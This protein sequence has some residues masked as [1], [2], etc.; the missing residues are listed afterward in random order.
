VDRGV[1]HGR[2]RRARARVIE[3]WSDHVDRDL[4][5]GG[6]AEAGGAAAD[7][8]ADRR[9]HRPQ[10]RWAPSARTIQR[11]FARTGLNRHPDGRAPRSYGRFEAAARNDRWTGDA[12]HGP[13]VANRKTYLL[14]FI[15]DHSRVVPGHRW[16]HAEDTVRLEAALRS[17][18][19]AR[20]IPKAVHMDNGSAMVS[21]QLLRACAVLGI[22]LV[23]ST[24]RRP[25]GRGK[26]ERFFR[27]VR[28]QFL[29]EVTTTPVADIGELNR[30]FT[31]WLE[32][33]YHR[34]VH[35]ETAEAPIDRFDA[36]CVKLPTTEQ[37]H[38]A[39]L[40][41]ETR[42][43]TKVATVSLHGN[44]YQV[45]ANLAGRKVELVF[46]PFDLTD[47]EVRLDGRPMGAAVPHRIGRH[48]HPAARP[49]PT[50]QPPAPVVCLRKCRGFG[51]EYPKS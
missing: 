37:L 28:D 48:S 8:R 34:S 46:D 40:W 9:G 26:I 13:I 18:L 27:T 50:Q 21:K 4:G 45:D 7:R 35:S 3:P 25:E 20:G 15:D 32:T 39:F 30:L 2:V 12:L 41:S 19:A 33:V 36:T 51:W 5:P 22:R 38:E 23:H 16:T 49:D 11:H 1:P 42:T 14:A 31:A 6:A 43:V 10:R 44:H 47:I 24:V 29:V 17:G